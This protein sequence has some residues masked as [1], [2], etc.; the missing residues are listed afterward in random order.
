[1]ITLFLNLFG[2]KHNASVY[3]LAWCVWTI[4]QISMSL[5]MQVSVSSSVVDGLSGGLSMFALGVLPAFLFRYSSV[6]DDITSTS[7]GGY[8]AFLLL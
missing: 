3:C 7:I 4:C 2:S 8:F 5:A 6:F 1:M